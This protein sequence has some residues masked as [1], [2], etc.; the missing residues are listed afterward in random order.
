M[1]DYRVK[2]FLTLCETMN[3]GKAA[4]RLNMTQP[5][6]TQHVQS[7]EREYE[8]KLFHYYG[9]TLE[10]TE[11]GKTLEAKAKVMRRIEAD[12]EALLRSPIEQPLCIGATK[13]IGEYVLPNALKRYLSVTERDLSLVVDNTDVLLRLLKDSRIDF[14]LIEGNFN[15][16]SFGFRTIRTEEFL[17]LCAAN[18]P[19]AGRTVSLEEAFGQT[20]I[21]REEGSGT[22]SILEEALLS[23]G[24]SREDFRRVVTVNHYGLI[25]EL[26]REGQ[27]VT[28][29]Y[30]S[31]ADGGALSV[32][33]VKRMELSHDFSYVYLPDTDT[34]SK[35]AAFEK[36]A[37]GAL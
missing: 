4:Q 29:G 34:E 1:I 33:W 23:R 6:V 10:K 13:T 2:T 28:F 7:L 26:V 14:A 15:K 19:F 24:R 30:R 12:T 20:L 22:R 36:A 35:I 11:A 9:R 37:G 3:Y 27:G 18:H 16:S 17:G 32:F 8:V 5:S 31:L 21:L 25:K